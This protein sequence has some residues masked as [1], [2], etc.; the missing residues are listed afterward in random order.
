[1]E[2]EKKERQQRIKE[3]YLKDYVPDEQESRF[4]DK[5]GFQD[6]W[7]NW[8]I[9]VVER[10]VARAVNDYRKTVERSLEDQYE[11]KLK[12]LSKGGEKK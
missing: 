12:A 7:F 10:E 9:E 5:K 2:K 8:W 3:K 1:M 6:P 4:L 11:K